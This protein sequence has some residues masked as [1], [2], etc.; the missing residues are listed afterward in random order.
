MRLQVADNAEISLQ[1]LPLL[2]SEHHDMPRRFYCYRGNSDGHI[3][4][5]SVLILEQSLL[6]LRFRGEDV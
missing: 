3:V 2:D 5:L 4:L 1:M 6:F